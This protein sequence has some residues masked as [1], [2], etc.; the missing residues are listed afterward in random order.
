MVLG[1]SSL[2]WALFSAD[3]TGS[4]LDLDARRQTPP[5]ELLE[6]TG[7]AGSTPSDHLRRLL[8][9]GLL[10][11]GRPRFTYRLPRGLAQAARMG[12][13]LDIV[14]I[15]FQGLRCICRYEKGGF[16]KESESRIRLKT[17]PKSSKRNKDHFFR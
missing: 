6:D 4:A 2:A 5:C 9:D 12:K 11:R 7:L 16:C 8:G 3:Q 13:A 10:V 15:A 1:W 17:A 14:G